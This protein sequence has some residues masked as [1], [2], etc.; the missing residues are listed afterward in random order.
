MLAS[1]SSTAD[2]L[3]DAIDKPQD[4]IP[5]EVLLE[6]CRSIERTVEVYC[7][8]LVEIGQSK[9]YRKV[10]FRWY[11]SQYDRLIPFANGSKYVRLVHRTAR[12]FLLDTVEGAEIRSFDTTSAFSLIVR[13]FRAYLGCSQLYTFS[14]SESL[15][16][17]SMRLAFR[18]LSVFD[19]RQKNRDSDLRDPAE[20]LSASPESLVETR[21]RSATQQRRRYRSISLNGL[22]EVSKSENQAVHS[23]NKSVGDFLLKNNDV[24]E[25]LA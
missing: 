16:P 5:E 20:W 23:I 22:A 21:A 14:S 10:K 3:L 7:F 11:G 18:A 19:K 9:V 1:D 13:L 2:L 15:P 6:K 24:S 4:M 17:L 12:D 8:G 25:L